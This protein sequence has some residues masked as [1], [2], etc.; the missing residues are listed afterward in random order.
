MTSFGTTSTLYQVINKL[1][2]LRGGSNDALGYSSYQQRWIN[3]DVYIFERKFFNDV[4]LIAIN[5]SP[6]LPPN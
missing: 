3:N 4:A 6:F 1:A 5:N 2:T